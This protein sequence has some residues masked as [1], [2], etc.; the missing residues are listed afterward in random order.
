[1]SSTDGPAWDLVDRPL[2]VAEL[3]IW[4]L[5]YGSFTLPGSSEAIRTHGLHAPGATGRQSNSF[6]YDTILG[7]TDYVFLAPPSIWGYGLGAVVLVDPSVLE[8]E[9]A[10]GSL[11]DA[12]EVMRQ[13]D[14]LTGNPN[15]SM[16]E[17]V[18]DRAQLAEL[19]GRSRS[20]SEHEA[21]AKG[22]PADI[23]SY[24]IE[25]HT[26]ERV[27]SSPE[28]AVY[29]SRY[30]MEPDAFLSALVEQNPGLTMRDFIRRECIGIQQPEFLV[31]RRISPSLLLGCILS[32]AWYPWTAPASGDTAERLSELVRL[33]TAR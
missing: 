7:R 11:Y 23:R 31:P 22:V 20:W 10:W 21:H 26:K 32:G 3:R 8:I 24:F 5:L 4:P 27:T 13:V 30:A 1:M 9:G 33:R 6:K 2:T 19:V 29:I 18:I 15:H 28:F 14:R 17:W 16:P 12:G 25:F